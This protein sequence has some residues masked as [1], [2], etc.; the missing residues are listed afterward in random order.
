MSN[1]YA[2][3]AEQRRL[4]LS[5]KLKELF[6]SDNV[7]FQPPEGFKMLYPCIRYKR[8]YKNINYANNKAYGVRQEYELI[9]ISKNPSEPI[10][11]TIPHEFE[12]CRPGRSYV[13]DNLY[14]EI[15]YIYW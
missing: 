12:Y 10:T 1:P 15:F 9:I 11:F 8:S 14:H 7:Y 13:A 4:E 3:H 6:G 5:A 2:D